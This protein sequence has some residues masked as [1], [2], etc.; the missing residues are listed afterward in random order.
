M[1]SG[2]YSLV[3]TL[4]GKRFAVLGPAAAGKTTMIN[5]LRTGEVTLHYEETE[6]PTKLK[7]RNIKLKEYELKIDDIVD[8]PGDKDFHSTWKMQV[9]TADVVCYI[10]DASRFVRGD[11]SYIDLVMSEMRHVSEWRKDRAREHSVLR[12]FVIGTHLDLVLDYRDADQLGKSSY[13]SAIWK[14]PIF[15]KLSRISGGSA[16]RCLAGS[17]SDQTGCEHLVGRVISEVAAAE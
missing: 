8:V 16:A 10:F 17:L 12:F 2:L 6:A 15:E 5:F 13:V 11:I 1:V 4:K 9:S 7:G 14:T 3:Q